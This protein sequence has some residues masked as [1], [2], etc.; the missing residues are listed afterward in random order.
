MKKWVYGPRLNMIVLLPMVVF[1]AASI[2]YAPALIPALAHMTAR[3]EIQVDGAIRYQTV[4]GFGAT[5]TPFETDG[6]YKA[7]DPSQPER[8]TAT[9]AQREAIARLLFTQL[10]LTR[11]RSVLHSF[12]PANDNDDPLTFNPLGYDWTPVN[13]HADFIALARPYG[14]TTPWASFAVEA[15]DREAW[16]RKLNNTCALDPE[17]MDEEVEWLLAAAV[18][19]A[20]L[21]LQ[22]PYMAIN[23]EP[24]LCATGFKIEIGDMVQIV[25]RLGARLQTEGLAT[26]IV[27]SDGWIPQNALLYMQAV[28]ED[29]EARPYVGALAYHAYDG[30]DDP[31]RILSS[32]ASG[33]PPQA[34][35]EI[36]QRIRDLAAQYDLPVWM[37]E[38]C[39]CVPRA[40]RDY[41]LLLARINHVHDE[42]TITDA[43][44]FDAINLFFL[45]RPRV[46]DELVHVY[47]RPDG[48]LERYEISTYGYL[49]GH[50]SHFVVP[51]SIRIR[52]NSSDPW[53]RVTAFERP[54]GKLI[55]VAINNNA[56]E[57]SANIT[58]MGLRQVLST[59]SVTSS[60]EG[61]IWQSQPDITVRAHR[62]EALLPPLSVT[63]LSVR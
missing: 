12:E 19:F 42:L 57:V 39:Y 17:K 33:N 9:A 53:V 8:V 29:P 59:L 52:A 41:E 31:E 40:F 50:Y 23:N 61:S 7:H 25:K 20:E 45:Q 51:G 13:P 47:F 36:R 46:D 5:L 15:G 30:Y 22:L 14:L 63:T 2:G 60:Q 37:T 28:L 62:A 1:A 44:A 6:I 49:L 4:S 27:V 10:G 3:V 58:L 54:D 35:V 43:S 34:A 26:K 38:I 24:D 21:G 48:S 56:V 16:L 32:S 55:L 11:A 18:H